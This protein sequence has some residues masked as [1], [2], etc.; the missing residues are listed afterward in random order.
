MKNSFPYLQLCDARAQL[1]QLRREISTLQYE[2]SRFV[3]DV[4]CALEDE[5]GKLNV[6]VQALQMQLDFLS[7]SRARGFTPVISRAKHSTETVV[8]TPTGPRSL[9]F[10]PPLERNGFRRSIRSPGIEVIRLP[11]EERETP[12]Q[13]SEPTFFVVDFPSGHFVPPPVDDRGDSIDTIFSDPEL[14]DTDPVETHAPVVTVQ[15]PVAP[16]P[17]QPRPRRKSGRTRAKR[18]PASEKSR[19][20]LEIEEPSE[21]E[22][23][24][25]I[26]KLLEI[27]KPSEPEKPPEPEK[28]LEPQ[29]PAEIEEPPELAKPLEPEKSPGPDESAVNPPAPVPAAVPPPPRKRRIFDWMYCV[30]LEREPKAKPV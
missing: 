6:E 4:D 28:P 7:R 27:G 16:P 24:L 26:E 2:N 15:Q 22:K 23:L 30:I 21:I 10:L 17:D 11:Q 1:E 14:F 5:V 12:V 13:E 25:D 8:P 19:E 20:P 3:P 29:K 18:S 9:S